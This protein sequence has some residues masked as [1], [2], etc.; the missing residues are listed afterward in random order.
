MCAFECVYTVGIQYII[1]EQ[2]ES[3]LSVYLYVCVFPGGF[4]CG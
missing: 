3:L 4:A 2:Q 1:V